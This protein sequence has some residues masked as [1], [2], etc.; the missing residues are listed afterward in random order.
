MQNSLSLSPKHFFRGK[1]VFCS[2]PVDLW[3]KTGISYEGSENGFIYVSTQKCFFVLYLI[4]TFYVAS[5]FSLV[6]FSQMIVFANNK[7][8]GQNGPI[9]KEH[10]KQMVYSTSIICRYY[11]VALE[12]TLLRL[13]ESDFLLSRYV[14]SNLVSPKSWSAHIITYHIC[15]SKNHSILVVSEALQR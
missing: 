15:N 10:I 7:F 1:S 12:T 3:S 14:Q 9:S 8:I 6:S 11:I 2:H 4:Q 5:T 13:S